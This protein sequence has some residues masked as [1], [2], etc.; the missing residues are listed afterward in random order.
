MTAISVALAAYVLHDT[1]LCDCDNIC[2][3]NAV[4]YYISCP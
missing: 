3:D 4:L 1:M 2:A